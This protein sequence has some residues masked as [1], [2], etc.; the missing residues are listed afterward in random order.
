M[1]VEIG[2][3]TFRETFAAANTEANMNAYL[4]TAFAVDQIKKDLAN[5]RC[6]FILLFADNRLAGYTKLKKAESDTNDQRKI[7]IEKLYALQEFIGKQVGQTLMQTCLDLAR[8]EG[9]QSV[10]LGVWEH[11][12]RAIAF[13]EKWG[14]KKVG[15]HAFRLGDDIQTD[16][17]ME[18]TID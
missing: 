16:L 12:A 13:Y 7:E 11:N 18:K 15:D 6:I 8:R 2:K 1:L 5:P 4:E 14:F 17:L 10:W 9:Y 3:K